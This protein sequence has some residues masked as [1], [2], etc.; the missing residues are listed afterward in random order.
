MKLIYLY[1]EE[2]RTFNEVELNFDS[3]I[4]FVYS[5]GKLSV[6]SHDS[7][8]SDFFSLQNGVRVVDSISAIVGNNG[9]GKTSVAALLNYIFVL[10][11][12]YPRYICVCEV[13][14]KII[15]Y[16]NLINSLE[17]SGPQA[18]FGDRWEF[19]TKNLYKDAEGCPF[20]VLYY[21]PH[22]HPKMIWENR[23]PWCYDISSVSN[24]NAAVGIA[25]NDPSHNQDSPIEVLDRE[26]NIARIDFMN[27]YA[28][29]S[30]AD[31]TDMPFPLPTSIE[32]KVDLT[33]LIE[34]EGY[35]FDLQKRFGDNNESVK[36]LARLKQILNT[37]NPLR[38]VLIAFAIYVSKR[39]VYVNDTILHCP[40]ERDLIDLCIN[41]STYIEIKQF[42]ESD[43]CIESCKRWKNIDGLQFIEFIREWIKIFSN[44][45]PD[46][47]IG[48]GIRVR[49]NNKETVAA[50]KRLIA[51]NYNL[52]NGH[53]SFMAFDPSDMSAG[54]CSFFNLFALLYRRLN[55]RAEPIVG[56]ILLFLDEVESTL[57][58]GWQRE[59]VYNVI[60]F[61]EHYA[62][63]CKVHVIFS[64]HS[65]ILLSDVP[66]ENCVF[67][68][69]KDGV[70]KVVELCGQAGE[71]NTFGANIFD[72]YY[73]SF[74]MQDGTIGK[75]AMSKIYNLERLGTADQNRV[76]RLVGD[77]F[78]R[79][80]LEDRFGCSTNT[81]VES[82]NHYHFKDP[83]ID[84]PRE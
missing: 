33:L 37:G 71:D 12:P 41:K 65:P 10:G 5:K 73:H 18:V 16:S 46:S 34:F 2:F 79:G 23:N 66:K 51:A 55:S 69:K 60:W 31:N 30:E 3:N 25:T 29:K 7:L 15:C 64:T 26:L 62:K 44:N 24:M 49:L 70:T 82:T 83:E 58:P 80:M 74:F 27:S 77:P 8:N 45:S 9:A 54:E 21:T 4:R 84:Y 11:R 75:F 20:S 40:E 35:V 39:F 32:I 42:V 61:L 63:D 76:V 72:M 36:Y 17:D 28:A 68:E 78:V 43:D 13:N 6:E 59:L 53:E 14:A 22:F 52:T 1:I 56:P 81:A 19:R 47:T 50:I 57:H 38:V 67:L 48:H